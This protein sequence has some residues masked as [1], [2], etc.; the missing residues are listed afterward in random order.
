MQELRDDGGVIALAP[1]GGIWR[2]TEIVRGRTNVQPSV[3]V[4]IHDLG[5]VGKEAK[6]SARP[7]SIEND[8]E[9]SAQIE[10]HVMEEVRGHNHDDVGQRSVGSKIGWDK[11]IHGYLTLFDG[12]SSNR[13][14]IS[15]K[16]W[17]SEMVFH[18]KFGCE[19]DKR[20]QFG[21]SKATHLDLPAIGW[22][23]EDRTAISSQYIA[24][25]EIALSN[26][27]EPRECKM[28]EA[29]LGAL[30]EQ[31]LWAPSITGIVPSINHLCADHDSFWGGGKGRAVSLSPQIS[32]KFWIYHSDYAFFLCSL[33]DHN[34]HIPGLSLRILRESL[35]LG[36]R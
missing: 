34:A 22:D 4:R 28:V 10:S 23:R 17:G 20:G 2:T 36:D 14:L 11:G 31:E 12:R 26:S 15:R 32:P 5:D 25:E 19:E 27:I 13:I 8:V 21:I 24:R 6:P 1:S 16:F 30:L 29:W 9:H 33:R 18:A 35:A 3:G 7:G